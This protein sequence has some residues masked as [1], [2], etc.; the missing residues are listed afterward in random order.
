MNGL[1][2]LV[3]L[4]ETVRS[5]FVRLGAESHDL[6]SDVTQLRIQSRATGVNLLNPLFDL[7]GPIS[8]RERE[9]ELLVDYVLLVFGRP[10]SSA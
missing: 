9:F 1:L 7:L 5:G 2:I 8:T 6:L 10:P 4:S 3:C